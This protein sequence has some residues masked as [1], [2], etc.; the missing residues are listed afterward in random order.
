LAVLQEREGA[1]AE[2]QA[3]LDRRAIELEDLRATAQAAIARRCILSLHESLQFPAN[4]LLE[5]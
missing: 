3:R 5:G 2:L 4:S 1:L